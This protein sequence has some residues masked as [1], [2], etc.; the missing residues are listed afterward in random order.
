MVSEIR[1][2]PA[3]S[4]KWYMMSL[5]TAASPPRCD[6]TPTA[7][8]K[9]Q[10]HGPNS[11]RLGRAIKCLGSGDLLTSGKWLSSGRKLAEMDEVQH[12]ADP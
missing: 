9:H 7:D 1:T 10:S 2:N 4:A 6:Y 12:F 8:L 5:A 3:E 11:A